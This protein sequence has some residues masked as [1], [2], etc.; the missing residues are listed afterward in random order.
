[1]KIFRILIDAIKI[2]LLHILFQ[3]L[4]NKCHS[5][6]CKDCKSYM[7]WNPTSRPLCAQCCVIDQALEKWGKVDK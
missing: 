2:R 1:M 7:S 4:C 3:D 6:S 5:G